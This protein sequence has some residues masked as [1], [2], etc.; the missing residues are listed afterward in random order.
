MTSNV[1]EE[2]VAMVEDL[3][4]TYQAL[5]AAHR[6]GDGADPGEEARTQVMV[7]LGFLSEMEDAFT[8]L[9]DPWCLFQVALVQN[10]NDFLVTGWELLGSLCP[11][12]DLS[13]AAGMADLIGLNLTRLDS[14]GQLPEDAPDLPILDHYRVCLHYLTA[15]L[16]RASQ[17][18]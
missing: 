1:L 6:V 16:R 2:N 5:L 12:D 17:G 8:D 15:Q 9:E 11:G 13:V 7:A 4:R 10:N 14:M 3:D 18:A